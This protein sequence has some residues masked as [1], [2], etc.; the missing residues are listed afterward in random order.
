MPLQ[1]SKNLRLPFHFVAFFEHP[2]SILFEVGNQH[3][4]EK[5]SHWMCSVSCYQSKMGKGRRNSDQ[6]KWGEGFTDRNFDCKVGKT[7]MDGESENHRDQNG[8]FLEKD[9][10]HCFHFQQTTSSRNGR[11]NSS[12]KRIQRN[13]DTT[14]GADETHYYSNENESNSIRSLREDNDSLLSA[15]SQG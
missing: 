8:D 1:F 2:N 13:N 6:L 4:V 3:C 7:C 5:F 10:L 12:E 15:A 9:E 11:R 14:V